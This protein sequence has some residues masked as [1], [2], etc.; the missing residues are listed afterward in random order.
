MCFGR[1]ERFL[2]TQ[3]IFFC[4]FCFLLQIIKKLFS[5]IFVN[6]QD[7]FNEKKG[8][9]IQLVPYEQTIKLCT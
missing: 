1:R 7:N 2:N 9:E 6:G 4:F 5:S 3:W 8:P